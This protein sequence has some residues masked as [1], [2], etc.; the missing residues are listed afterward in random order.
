M[1]LADQVKAIQLNHPSWSFQESW[2]HLE[3]TRPEL[4]VQTERKP[5]TRDPRLAKEFA[6]HKRLEDSQKSEAIDLHV[7]RL[8]KI[9]KLMKERK[10]DFTTAFTQVCQEEN[11][12][13]AA[14]ATTSVPATVGGTGKTFLVQSIE[15]GR[16]IDFG[17]ES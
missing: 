12:K 6:K 7:E 11:A 14:A 9:H 4:F 17:A 2:N 1:K 8:S 15:C 10:L 5:L 3:T 13:K 16:Q